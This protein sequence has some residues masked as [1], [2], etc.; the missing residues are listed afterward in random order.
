MAAS[1]LMA[2]CIRLPLRLRRVPARDAATERCARAGCRAG[3][4]TTNS[5]NSISSLWSTTIRRSGVRRRCPYQ[6]RHTYACWMLSAGANPA[7]IASQMGHE[8]AEMIYT[9][10]S[11]WINALD[12]DQIEILSHRIG[13]YSSVPLVPQEENAQ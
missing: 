3:V 9:V 11:A 12:G 8:N 10:Y 2:F 7:F 13:G 1:I 6:T 4:P 5:V